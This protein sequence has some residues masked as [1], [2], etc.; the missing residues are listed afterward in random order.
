MPK[1]AKWVTPETH[2]IRVG[3][4][5][6]WNRNANTFL[7]LSISP[8][9]LDSL[10]VDV[11]VMYSDGFTHSMYA[12]DMIRLIPEDDSYSVILCEP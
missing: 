2:D 4:L 5:R 8:S 7:V 11:E 1:K 6:R 10:E 12:A 3:Q 9:T